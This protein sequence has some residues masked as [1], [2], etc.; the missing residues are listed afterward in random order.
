MTGILQLAKPITT[1]GMIVM[2]VARC[3]QPARATDPAP[4]ALNFCSPVYAAA[5]NSPYALGRQTG[6]EVHLVNHSS[7]TARQVS[8]RLGQ[9]ADAPTVVDRGT[10]A[11][12]VTVRSVFDTT[13]RIA[14]TCRVTDAR[15]GD[16]SSDQTPA[17][18]TAKR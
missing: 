3:G 1:L 13:E 15:F 10:F 9:G 2:V 8:I 5:E 12:G 18:V 4:I 16:D 14:N 6:V 11:P 17:A 7:A